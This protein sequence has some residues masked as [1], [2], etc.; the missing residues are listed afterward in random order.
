M[1]KI[2]LVDYSPCRSEAVVEVKII[3]VVANLKRKYEI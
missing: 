1:F 2:K 3:I